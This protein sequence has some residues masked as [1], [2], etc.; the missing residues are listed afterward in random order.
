MHRNVESQNDLEWV[1]DRCSIPPIKAEL[2]NDFK[3]IFRKRVPVFVFPAE[4]L[5]NFS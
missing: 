3:G 2:M 4:L 1:S 5:L